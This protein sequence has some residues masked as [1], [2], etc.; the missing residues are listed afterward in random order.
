MDVKTFGIKIFV[1]QKLMIRNILLKTTLI[2][3]IE[4]GEA[5]LKP[6]WNLYPS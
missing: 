2:Y 6:D 4:H 3:L 5:K 1:T